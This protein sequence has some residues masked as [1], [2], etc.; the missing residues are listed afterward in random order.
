MLRRPASGS[1]RRRAPAWSDPADR[2][3]SINVASVSRLRKLRQSKGQTSLSGAEYE[4]AL[5]KQHCV[6]HPRTSWAAVGSAAKQQQ[7]D[8]PRRA[9]FNVEEWQEPDEAAAEQLLTRGGGLLLSGAAGAGHGGVIAAGAIELSRLRDAN[10]ASA[11]DAVV[12]ALQFHPNGQLML[13]AGF[14]KRL[15]LFQVR[16]WQACSSA[17]HWSWTSAAAACSCRVGGGALCCWSQHCS[18]S[19]AT[20]TR[21]V[22]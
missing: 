22:T 8:G 14:D 3:L 17:W 19:A 6:L 20:L 5:R 15:K 4:A 9:A 7:G 12:Q 10:G 2:D 18:S 21:L 1:K 16:P 11:S 13:T